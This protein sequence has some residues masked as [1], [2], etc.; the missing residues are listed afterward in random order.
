MFYG[1]AKIIPVDEGLVVLFSNKIDK[2]A[3]DLY[4]VSTAILDGGKFLLVGLEMVIPI[5]VFRD[6]DDRCV[7]YIAEDSDTGY[8]FPT[9]ISKFYLNS[10]ALAKIEIWGETINSP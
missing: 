3:I 7:L 4:G 1:P 5:H 9:V 6:F 2:T 8:L 10:R